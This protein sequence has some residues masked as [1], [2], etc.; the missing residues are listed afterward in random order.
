M[1]LIGIHDLR[2][3]SVPVPSV[4]FLLKASIHFLYAVID[5]AQGGDNR[6]FVLTMYRMG[7]VVLQTTNHM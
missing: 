4:F 7:L 5:E 1:G 3:G 2:I 6:I